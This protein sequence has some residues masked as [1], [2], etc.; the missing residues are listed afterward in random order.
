MHAFREPLEQTAPVAM[1]VLGDSLAYGMGAT[2][3]ENGLSHL[4]FTQ[5]RAARPGRTYA[6]YGV[7]HSTMG[8]VLR[9]QIPLLHRWNAGFVLLIAGA[10]DLRFTHDAAVIVRRFRKLLESVHEAAPRAIVVA[11]GMPDVTQT[12]G[13]PA[14]LKLVA[15]RLCRRVNDAMRNMVAE[16]DDDFFD[17][18][19]FTRAPLRA[20]V[21]YLCNDGYHPGDFGHAEIAQR[22]YPAVMHALTRSRG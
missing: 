6:N 14:Y 3:V 7:P 1:A 13:V 2:R 15:A 22:A 16:Y 9:H 12:I 10:N 18:Y 11:G 4:I 20:D 19:E 17:L 5:V 21:P 8:D